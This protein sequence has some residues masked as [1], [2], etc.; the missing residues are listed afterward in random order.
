[1]KTIIKVDV[2]RINFPTATI[3]A[4]VGHSRSFCFVGVPQ[5]VQDLFVRIFKPDG[6]YF[7]MPANPRPGGA[8]DCYVIG[9]C[10][11]CVGSAHYELHGTDPMGNPT[12][13]AYGLVNVGPFS[14]TTAPIE[15]GSVMTVERIPTRDGAMV[16]VLMVRDEAGAWV[17]DAVVEGR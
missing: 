9:T 2:D 16:Q 14:V 7:D 15:P 10:F 12:A 1:M 17:L 3:H 5:D 6:S 4:R 11:P 13:V 8:W